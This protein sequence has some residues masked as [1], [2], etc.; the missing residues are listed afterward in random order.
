[1]RIVGGSVFDGEGFVSREVCIDG[2]VFAAEAPAGDG[3]VLDAFG[4]LCDPG[5]G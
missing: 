1:M 4:V 2:G 5:P 3:E